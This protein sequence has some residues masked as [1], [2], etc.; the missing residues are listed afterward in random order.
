ML[1]EAYAFLRP[2]AIVLHPAG[3]SEIEAIFLLRQGIDPMTLA[4]RARPLLPDYAGWDATSNFADTL[5]AWQL[6]H[7]RIYA[8]NAAMMS[9]VLADVQQQRVD[10]GW[11][12]G[13]SKVE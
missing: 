3:T 6:Y 2:P 8:A 5:K 1:L 4:P 10:R 13:S 11:S 12:V 7:E 9:I